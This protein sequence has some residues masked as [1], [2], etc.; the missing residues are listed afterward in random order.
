M[1]FDKLIPKSY[2]VYFDQIQNP[3]MIVN[4]EVFINF[5]NEKVIKKVLEGEYEYLNKK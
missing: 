1:K 3:N 2:E 4:Q 5:Q